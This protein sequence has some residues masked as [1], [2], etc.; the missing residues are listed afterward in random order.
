[1]IL[2]FFCNV[3]K[4]WYPSLQWYHESQVLIGSTV[5]SPLRTVRFACRN[6]GNRPARNSSYSRPAWAN[7]SR[8]T[9][10]Q[11]ALIWAIS[12]C[13]LFKDLSNPTSPINPLLKTINPAPPASVKQSSLCL[14]LGCSTE[15]FSDQPWMPRC[16]A[17]LGVLENSWPHPQQKPLVMGNSAVESVV[18]FWHVHCSCSAGEPNIY[19]LVMS[20]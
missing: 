5:I 14:P 15:S 2:T 10:L 1:M 4:P 20:K 11:Y 12:P 7:S 6:T 13:F 18:L 17:E 8:S 9:Q 16:E 3:A 19:P